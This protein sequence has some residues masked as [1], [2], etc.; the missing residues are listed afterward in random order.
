MSTVKRKAL[1]KK[2]TPLGLELEES[3]RAILANV[4]GEKRL[5]TRR[6]VLP[7]EVDVSLIG[8]GARMSQAEFARA[9]CI[10]RAR[11]RSGSRGAGSRTRRLGRTWRRSPRIGRLC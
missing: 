10:I 9:F 6:V 11:S 5:P 2:R 4:K 8:K 7:D 1:G 3:A